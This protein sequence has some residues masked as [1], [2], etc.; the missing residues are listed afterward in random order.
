MFKNAKLEEK[1]INLDGEKQL[2]QRFVDDVALTVKG[3]QLNTLNEESSQ[4][5]LK[6]HKEQAKFMTNG[7]T[8]DNIQIDGTKMKKVTSYKYLGQTI[9]ME[10]RTR[11]EVSMRI[12][13]GWSGDG[14]ARSRFAPYFQILSFYGG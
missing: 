11:Q 9:A 3:H 6:R 10:N 7:D 2:D 12:K 13:A 1:G 14:H 5:Y 4:I 8:T